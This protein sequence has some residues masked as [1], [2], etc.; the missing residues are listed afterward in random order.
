MAPPT[1]PAY[2]LSNFRIEDNRF[3]Q[4][5]MV[6]DYVRTSQGVGVV[7]IAGKTKNG[8]LHVMGFPLYGEQSGEIRLS[9]MFR[10]GDG[11]Y[12]VEIY[13]VAGAHWV[14]KS[15]GQC[16]VSNAVRLGNP[17]PVTKARA[18]TADEQAAFDKQQLYDKPPAEPLSGVLPAT[19][20]T[21]LVPG[22][23]V[24]AGY[25]GEW[26]DA[27]VVSLLERNRVGLKFSD[28]TSLII[29][30]R[31]DWIAV[32]PKVAEQVESAPGQFKP[33]MRVLAEGK[34]ALPDGVIALP[35]DVALYVGTPILY[36]R[37][38]RWK[39]AFIL[40]VD[41]K[42][43]RVRYDDLSSAFDADKPRAQFAIN[44][45]TLEQ[46]KNPKVAGQFSANISAGG[47]ANGSPFPSAP[48]KGGLA[49]PAPKRRKDY[50][51]DIPV[52]QGAQLVPA[53]LKL[54][55][56]TPVAGCWANKW[57]PVTVL[58]ENSDG[59]VNVHWNDYSDA[60][61][62]SMVRNQL[63]IEDKTV[64]KLQQTTSA[65]TNGVKGALRTWSDAS[66]GHKVEA[67]FVNKTAT[68][69]TIVTD[70]GREIT[71]PIEKLSNEDQAFLKSIPSEVPN[72]FAP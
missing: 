38:G 21:K 23:P 20:G 16:M 47:G 32:D 19:N 46:L 51:V 63:I 57:N 60:W 5:E 13:L 30:P 27:E 64:R 53:D 66:G 41:E 12:D 28:E 36:E 49:G 39:N 37:G 61:D 42:T 58:S 8:D 15:Y 72:P 62:C 67:R 35:D 6:I 43:I 44:K 65:A 18:W 14:G 40:N 9:K 25:Y 50:R 71:L 17:G 59:T 31:V 52:P 34:V 45:E 10:F 7:Q 26:V 4:A 24:K 3:G 29:R 11:K 33:S 54:T 22:M 48:V 55:K 56:G 2:R 69:V 68:D 1:A 70:A